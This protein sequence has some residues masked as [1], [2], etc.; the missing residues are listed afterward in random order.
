MSILIARL[1]RQCILIFIFFAALIRPAMAE[2][3]LVTSTSL[4]GPDSF[5]EAVEM[6]NANPG[7]DVIEFSPGLQVDA[8]NAQPLGQFDK[9][10]MANFTESVVID[11]NGGALIGLQIWVNTKGVQITTF[12]PGDDPDIQQIAFMPGFLSV[13]TRTQDN[14]GVE[15][16]VKNLDIT[17]FNQIAKVWKNASLVL[18]NFNAF[19]TWATYRCF[20]NSPI[21]V[22]EGGSLTIR[23]SLFFDSENWGPDRA[24]AAI[25]GLD[26]GDLNI[27]RSEFSLLNF[28]G[29]YAIDW[30]GAAGSSVNIV[31]SRFRRSGGI[32]VDG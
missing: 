8:S 5:M 24:A 17:Q 16:T 28:G 30:I 25:F 13:G 7:P 10:V 11:G 29:Q 1:V 9:Y 26:A 32:L 27:E 3:Y 12:C 6:A 14:T 15:V 23:D 20:G 21:E 22:S 18:E 4:T 19:E 31:N 2:T